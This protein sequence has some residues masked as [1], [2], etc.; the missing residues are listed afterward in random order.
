MHR[1]TG[2]V[3]LGRAQGTVAIRNLMTAV[4]ASGEL[5]A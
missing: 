2:A 4:L 5:C 1:D 3:F